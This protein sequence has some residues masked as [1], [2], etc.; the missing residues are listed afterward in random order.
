[1]FVS[2]VPALTLKGELTV[3]LFAGEQIVTEGFT[4]L[5]VHAAERAGREQMANIKA[6][7]AG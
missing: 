3:A 1:V 4:V 2:V 6:Q 5:S 7:I